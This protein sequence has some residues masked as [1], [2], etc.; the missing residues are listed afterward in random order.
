MKKLAFLLL[1]FAARVTITGCS[2]KSD[3]KTGKY[4]LAVI[5]KGTVHE[6]WK[7]VHAGAQKAANELNVDIIWKG[8]LKEDDRESQIAVVENILAR[9]VDGIVLAPLDDTALRIPVKNAQN[10]GIP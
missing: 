7:T 5:P 1:I 4:T 9:G 2:K 6:F 8:P 3:E 10:M